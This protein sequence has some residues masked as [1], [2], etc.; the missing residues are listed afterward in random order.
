MLR[1]KTLQV[2]QVYAISPEAVEI[3]IVAMKDKGVMIITTT[4]IQNDNRY[5]ELVE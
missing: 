1:N 4:R 3:L 5:G 2:K